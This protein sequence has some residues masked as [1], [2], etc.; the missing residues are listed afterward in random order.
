MAISLPGSPHSISSTSSSAALPSF[1]ALAPTRAFLT[2]AAEETVLE[3]P[4]LHTPVRLKVDAGP[5]CGG[6][7]WPSG[8]VR[9]ETCLYDTP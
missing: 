2:I 5:S 6:I 4:D 8:E 1:E 3:I 9:H 7:V